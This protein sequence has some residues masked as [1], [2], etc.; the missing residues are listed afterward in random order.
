MRGCKIVLLNS[1]Y[2]TLQM[3]DKI[4]VYKE[5]YLP[6][7][8]QICIHMYYVIIFMFTLIHVQ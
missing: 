7:D 6:R 3:I 1:S 5:H 2:F 4:A 8:L